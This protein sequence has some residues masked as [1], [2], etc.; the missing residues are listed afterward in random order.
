MELVCYDC[1]IQLVKVMFVYRETIEYF[2]Q[3]KQV[4][5]TREKYL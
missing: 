5:K 4:R 1:S 3:S 2:R